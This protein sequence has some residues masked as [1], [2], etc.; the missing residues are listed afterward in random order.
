MGVSRLDEVRWIGLQSNKDERGVLTAIEGGQHT[1]FDIQRVF[2]VHHAV[3]DRGGH[4]HRDTDQLIVAAAGSLLVEVSDGKEWR[5]FEL[6]DADRG[7]YVPRM[8]FIQLRRFSA[9]TVCMVLAST[10][11]DIKRSIRTWDDYLTQLEGA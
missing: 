8:V 4:A 3:T 9:E 11:Y 6:T 10:H 1:P 2:L 7:L 5:S